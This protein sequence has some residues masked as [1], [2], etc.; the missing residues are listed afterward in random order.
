MNFDLGYALAWALG[1]IFMAGA[2][3]AGVRIGLRQLRKDLNGAMLRNRDDHRAIADE[4]W[5]AALAFTVI[6]EK[7]EDRELLARFLKR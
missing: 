5:N 3:F 4:V 1:L 2:F 7:R 6:L